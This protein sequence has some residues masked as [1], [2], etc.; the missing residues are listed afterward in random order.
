MKRIAVFAS[1]S[2]S[3]AENLVNY[4][5]DSEVARIS[6]V[7][8]NRK[9]AFVF[10]RMKRLEI[11]CIY[12]PKNDFVNGSILSALKA[13]N[14]DMI[15]LAGFLLLVPD[16]LLSEYSGK[17]INVHPALLPGFGGK[18]MYGKHVHEAVVKAGEQ[19]SGITIHYVNERFDEGE[20]I[21]QFETALQ[22]GD[23]PESVAA[24][25]HELEMKFFPKV[26]EDVIRKW[27]E[28]S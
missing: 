17:I 12:V 28:I 25:I 22:P 26:V 10:E 24:K 2:G 15:V 6:L 23:T 16:S 19:K 4:F 9:E 27:D 5:R 20:I 21:A 7:V 11:P 8:C 1:G 13:Y 14:I 18:G 3:N